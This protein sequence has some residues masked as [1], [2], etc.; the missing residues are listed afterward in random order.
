MFDYSTGEVSDPGSLRGLPYQL[1]NG[2][3]LFLGD[4]S[5]SGIKLYKVETNEVISLYSSNYYDKIIELENGDC[6]IGGG[7]TGS[8]LLYYD[9]TVCEVRQLLSL[10]TVTSITTQYD[11]TYLIET[12]DDFDYE[13]NPETDTIKL[14]YTVEQ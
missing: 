4:S 7:K 14:V 8:G 10:I 13:Y 6:L 3:V 9:S 1:S 5:Y 2:D 11:G 12:S